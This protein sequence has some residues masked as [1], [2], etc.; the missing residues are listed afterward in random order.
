MCACVWFLL[1]CSI[2]LY[3]CHVPPNGRNEK[4]DWP[5]RAHPPAKVKHRLLP[6]PPALFPPLQRALEPSTLLFHCTVSLQVLDINYLCSL[7]LK[8]HHSLISL[9]S[10]SKTCAWVTFHFTG[11]YSTLRALHPLREKEGKNR[12]DHFWMFFFFFS[13]LIKCLSLHRWLRS[14][15]LLNDIQF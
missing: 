2:I 15:Y 4:N 14:N 7:A 6:P 12:L 11:I 8:I 1:H 9:I 10:T 13:R 3:R 5:Q